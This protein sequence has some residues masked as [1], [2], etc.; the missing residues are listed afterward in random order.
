[1]KCACDILFQGRARIRLFRILLS[2]NLSHYGL[3][4]M[5]C[6]AE[7]HSECL[8]ED[9][10]VADWDEHFNDRLTTGKAPSE[11]TWDSYLWHFCKLFTTPTGIILFGISGINCSTPFRFCDSCW[12]T[13]PIWKCFY[14]IYQEFKAFLN[15]IL[16]ET[17]ILNGCEM[18]GRDGIQT[19]GFKDQP[20]FVQ[21]R[22]CINIHLHWRLYTSK[23]PLTLEIT[24]MSINYVYFLEK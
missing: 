21:V 23:Y 1:M 15:L 13:S 5:A 12:I 3:G 10:P 18:L 22:W 9:A 8:T 7:S 17:C 16:S 14:Q 20:V 11:Q 2:S 6:R 4:D 24:K 19:P